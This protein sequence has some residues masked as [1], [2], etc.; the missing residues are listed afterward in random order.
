MINGLKMYN[1]SENDLPHKYVLRICLIHAG[2]SGM[3]SR[4][5][6][7]GY[8]SAETATF[9]IINW[10]IYKTAAKNLM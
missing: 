9:N 6:N 7:I 2:I 8:A 5:C 10:L 4:L 3:S 1:V